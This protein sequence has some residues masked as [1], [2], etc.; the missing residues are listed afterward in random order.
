MRS[1][2]PM[3]YKNH[4]DDDFRYLTVLSVNSSSIKLKKI[5]KNKFKKP[6]L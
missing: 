5:N 6:Y 1:Q 2:N 4:A 3:S